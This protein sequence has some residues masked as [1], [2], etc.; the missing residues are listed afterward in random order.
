M[1]KVLGT[2]TVRFN[3]QNPSEKESTIVLI[4]R[5]TYEGKSQR[6]KYSPGLKVKTKYWDE[7]SQFPKR[8]PHTTKLIGELARLEKIVLDVW[9][10]ENLPAKEFREELRHLWEGKPKVKG[11]EGYIP[12]FH[13]FVSDYVLR[14]KDSQI[15][16]GT[17]K[18]LNTWKNHLADFV[19]YQQKELTFDGIDREFRENFIKWCYVENNHSMN[20]VR[21]GLTIIRQ[22]MAEAEEQGFHSNGYP[23]TK[24]FLLK[25][26][27]PQP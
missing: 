9:E 1:P 27:L 10:K 14:K 15:S 17:W 11:T 16:R 8:N 23:Q 12:S 26:Y 18:N 22:F 5:Y 21:K 24:S 25:N 2:P 20:Y 3:L 6:L 7:K 4:F 13:E 19:S